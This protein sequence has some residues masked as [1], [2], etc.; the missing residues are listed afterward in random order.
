MRLDKPIG[1]LLLL[2][3]TLSALWLAAN[4][5]PRRSLVLIFAVGTLVMRSAGCAMNDW[6]DRDFDAHVAR[7][8]Q[9]S[10]CRSASSRPGKRSRS[11]PRAPCVAFLLVLF[12]NRATMLWSIAALAIA[13]AYP[14]VKRFFALPAGVPRHRVLV[15]HPD[16]VRGRAE[17]RACRSRGRCSASTCSGSIAY[18]TEYA[19]V[20]RAD[21]VKIG[22]RTSALTFGRADV[23]RRRALLRGRTSRGMAWVGRVHALGAHLLRGLAVALLIAIH[24]LWIIRARDPAACFRAFLGNHWLGMAVFAGVALDYAYWC[25]ALAARVVRRGKAARADAAGRGLPPVIAADARVLILGSFPSEASLAA[26]QYYAHPRNHFWPILGAVLDEP[27]RSCPMRERLRASRAP[28]VAIWD[29]IVAL[30]AR[31][32]PRCGDSQCGAGRDRRVRRVARELQ[33]VC[34][35][36]NTAGRAKRGMGAR[37]V[38]DAGAAVDEPGVHAPRGGKARRLARAAPMAGGALRRW[39][40]RCCARASR[41]SAHARRIE[42]VTFRVARPRRERRARHAAGRCCCC[43]ASAMPPGGLPGD[44]CAAWLRR[45][46]FDARK[47]TRTELAERMALRADPLRAR[48]L[49]RAVRRQLPRARHARGLHDQARRAHDDGRA[50]AARRARRARRISR[51]RGGHR[52]RSHRARRLV[53][54]RQRGAAGDQHARRCR[55]DAILGAPDAP[56]FF[57]AAV[58]FYPGCAT[59]LKARR[60]LSARRADA[61]PHRHAATTGRRPR[62]ASSSATRWRRANEDLLVTTYAGSYH[63]FDSPTGTLVHRTDVPNGVHPG[64]GVHVGPNPGGARRGQRQRSRIPAPAPAS[65]ATP[66]KRNGVKWTSDCAIASSSSPARARASASRARRRSPREGARV[67]LVSRSRANL[68]AALA[69]IRHVRSMRRWRSSPI[70]ADA[71]QATAMVDEVEADARADRRPGELGGRCQALSAGRSVGR[72]LARRDGRE[73]LQLHPSARRGGQAHGRARPRHRS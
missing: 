44:R 37:G 2:W 60:A 66:V 69:K 19:M 35:N 12:T 29:T 54:R 70:S 15:R 20:D 16:G 3:P 9:P 36:G 26:R 22:I 49:R 38:R 52:A 33:A 24:H 42:T 11:R 67:A 45:H 53:A 31:R 61:H 51:T 59:P 27:L 56:P 32:Q 23:A 8:A 48:R 72:G 21:D 5:A 47:A 30:R 28:R 63:A 6:A 17:S 57:R 55:R 41:C 64:Q 14:F 65:I 10:A 18:D 4:G 1:T 43:R 73:I 58:A 50:A 39:S 25:R 71:A 46:V 62:P 34:F 13:V 40:S 7:T 68:D